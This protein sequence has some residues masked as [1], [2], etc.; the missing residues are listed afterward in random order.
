MVQISEI[1]FHVRLLIKDPLDTAHSVTLWV[2]AFHQ[3]ARQG[4]IEGHQLPHRLPGG[5][6]Q[7]D[8]SGGR[9]RRPRHR[10]NPLLR[11]QHQHERVR[12]QLRLQEAEGED[13]QERLEDARLG[14]GSQR[15]LQSHREQHQ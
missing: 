7:R 3:G 13:R 6:P 10:L 15:L 4:E 9:V 1:A 14:S 5:D 2:S 12:H 11:E 8:G